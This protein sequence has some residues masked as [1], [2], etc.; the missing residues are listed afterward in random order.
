MR[1]LVDL[2]DELLVLI[3]EH[4]PQKDLCRVR[5]VCRALRGLASIPCF[6]SIFTSLYYD[7]KFLYS[8]VDLQNGPLTR[9]VRTVDI[10]PCDVPAFVSRSPATP[11]PSD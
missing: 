3:F 8:F 4:L 9:F 2:P 10:D 11:H 1:D 5:F 7:I 6:R